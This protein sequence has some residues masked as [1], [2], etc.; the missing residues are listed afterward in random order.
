MALLAKRYSDISDEAG[1]MMLESSA[2]VVGVIQ[3][4]GGTLGKAEVH[5]AMQRLVDNVYKPA[6]NLS[7]LLRRQRASWCV[8]FPPVERQASAEGRGTAASMPGGVVYAF[9]KIFDGY[10]MKDVDFDGDEEDEAR[11]TT[12]LHKHIEV[13]VGPGLFKSGNIDG[14]RYDMETVLEKSE[15]SC[16]P[17]GDVR[18]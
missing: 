11:P 13:I 17:V 8:R 16:M 5:D 4:C 10:Y 18:D 3:P 14:E 15:V 6:L 12:Y 7:R 1:N 9:P 2:A